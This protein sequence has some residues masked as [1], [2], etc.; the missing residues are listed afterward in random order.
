MN[1][2]KQNREMKEEMAN[3]R[4]D[5]KSYFGIGGSVPRTIVGGFGD[6]LNMAK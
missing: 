2:E 4:K 5:M 6:K 3:L 1:L